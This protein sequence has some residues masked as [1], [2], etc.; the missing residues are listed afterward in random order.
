MLKSIV[1][2]VPYDPTLYVVALS[3]VALAASFV[4]ARVFYF[5]F[6][7]LMKFFTSRTS[8]TLDDRILT[9]IKRPLEL[10]LLVACFIYAAS[11]VKGLAVWADF[12]SAFSLAIFALLIGYLVSEATGA[13][14]R[15]YYEEGSKSSRMVKLDV[16]LIPLLR[17][18]SKVLIYAVAVS[19]ALSFLGIN[20]TAILAIGSIT[21]LILGLASQETLANFFAGLA[22][23]TDRPFEYGDYLRFPTGEVAVLKR[24]G[25]RSSVL[26]DID[27][28]TIVISNSE[29][30]KQRI[31]NL[32]RPSH[33]TRLTLN[34]AVAHGQDLERIATLITRTLS[35]A[36]I[37]GMVKEEP[38]TVRVAAWSESGIRFAVIFTVDDFRSAGAATDAAYRALYAAF[39]KNRVKLP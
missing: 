33:K 21:G 12:L 22:L 4:V 25:L 32:C 37:P 6:S 24:I 31:T 3:I 23:L 34:L 16:S 38:P 5:A 14:L 27:H 9:A 2:L 7:K 20:I 18:S 11:V 39:R 28:N 13:A 19:F 30:A 8:T 15:W 29:L 1:E 36:R 17:K 26:E 10:I 35:G